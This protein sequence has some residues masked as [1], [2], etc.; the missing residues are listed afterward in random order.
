[1]STTE[2][3]ALFAALGD[4]TRLAL[5]GRLSSG[6][7]LSIAALSQ[8]FR[9]S[10]QAVTKHLRVLEESGLVQQRRCGRETRFVLDPDAIAAGRQYLDQV[11]A[12]WEAA[13]GRL[14]TFIDEQL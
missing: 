9:T 12:Q 7:A 13:L 10:R 4:P 1:M 8:D 5:V 14:A 2:P 3:A 11:A 6:S